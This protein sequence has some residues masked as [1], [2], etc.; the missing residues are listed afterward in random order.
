MKPGTST[1]DRVKAVARA[2]LK[3]ALSCFDDEDALVVQEELDR[4]S[5]LYCSV[6]A[7]TPGESTYLRLS[8]PRDAGEM[9]IRDVRVAAPL[10]SAGLGRQLV[11]AAEGSARELEVEVVSVYPVGSSGLFWQKMGYRRHR[12]TARALSKDMR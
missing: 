5:I 11:R 1:L 8:L 6:Q 9:W 7:S 12:S 4:V 10:R 3:E 2:V